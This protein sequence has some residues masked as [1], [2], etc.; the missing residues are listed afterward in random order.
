MIKVALVD[1]HQLIRT[2]LRSLL[3]S[4]PGLH[5]IAEASNGAEALEV[6]AAER[7]D[8]VLMDPSMP[9]MDG[10]EATARLRESQPGVRVVVLTSFSDRAR[11]QEA[12]GAGAIGYLLKDCEPSELV[13]AV[14]AAAAGHVPLDPRVAGALLPTGESTNKGLSPRELDVLKLV[15]QGL[16]NKQIARALGITERTVKTHVGNIFREIGVT[17]R[18]SA[19]MWARDHLS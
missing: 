8:V 9:V 17:D 3:D 18:T 6:L 1:D 14:H 16:A 15:S 7:A 11:V 2:G 5:V 10:V 4:D 19:A 12:I 13:N